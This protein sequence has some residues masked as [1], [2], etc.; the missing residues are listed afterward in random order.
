MLGDELDGNVIASEKDA[1]LEWDVARGKEQVTP[2]GGW[3][4]SLG[5]GKCLLDE[6][7]I[8]GGSVGRDGGVNIDA[9]FAQTS[10]YCKRV[11]A[12][13]QDYERWRV[14]IR[15]SCSGRSQRSDSQADVCVPFL[16]R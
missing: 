4:R 8:V 15:R 2:V 5:Y 14:V 6:S 9:L 1:P 16:N 11:V 3:F 10:Y 12:A 13:A 7:R